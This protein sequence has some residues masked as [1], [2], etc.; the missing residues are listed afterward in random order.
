[1]HDLHTKLED[2]E[3]NVKALIRK[4]NAATHANETLKN[5]NNKLKEELRKKEAVVNEVNEAANVRTF[6]SPISEEKYN[7]IKEDIK[8]CIVEIDDCIKMIEK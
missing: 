8:S 1:M 7:T 5:E 3:R 6:S 2:L 4:L